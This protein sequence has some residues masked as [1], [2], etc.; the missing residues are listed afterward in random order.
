MKHRIQ[1]IAIG[2]G[3]LAIGLAV[4][5]GGFALPWMAALP[6]IVNSAVVL[7]SL[8]PF[9][10]SASMIAKACIAGVALLAFA[11]TN[12]LTKRI[13]VLVQR[14]NDKKRE[15]IEPPSESQP[16]STHTI[17]DQLTIELDNGEEVKRE[18]VEQVRERL[19]EAHFSPQ[20]LKELHASCSAPARADTPFNPAWFKTFSVFS[21]SNRPEG[22]SIRRTK[23]IIRSSLMQI[24]DDFYIKNKGLT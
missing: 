22:M 6:F 10:I 23:G 19:A 24:G 9:A 21:S 8:M 2:V 5:T 4:L 11:S 1:L 18:E 20:E 12:W 16:D 3:L 14:A 7:S 17:Q 13:A 15:F